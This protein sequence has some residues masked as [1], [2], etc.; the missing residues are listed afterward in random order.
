M[1]FFVYSFLCYFYPLLTK[2]LK[3][4]SKQ[5]ASVSFMCYSPRINKLS[6]LPVFPGGDIPTEKVMLH[7][8]G[9][10]WTFGYV[11]YLIELQRWSS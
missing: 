4:A 11:L 10:I 3:N 6:I 1:F 7:C 2:K 9:G 8:D 5:K